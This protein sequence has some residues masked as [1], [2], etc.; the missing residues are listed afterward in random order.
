MRL[1]EREPRSVVSACRT[2]DATVGLQ[3]EEM[4]E[5]RSLRERPGLLRIVGVDLGNEV[6]RRALLLPE[7]AEDLPL[8]LRTMT[9]V[10][11]ELL[12]HAE[13]RWAVARID[14]ARVELAETPQRPQI[15]G[16]VAVRRVDEAR[17][18]S[19]HGV[20]REQGAL[21]RNEK[22]HRVARVPRRVE[23]DD[24]QLADREL[25]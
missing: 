14:R 23:R 8:A 18:P 20:A 11:V 2:T 10:F 4:R 7:R 15:G 24:G 13:D 21:L 22:R 3:L 12:R 9:D 19:Q 16:E 25:L 1:R 6:R 17:S 5:H